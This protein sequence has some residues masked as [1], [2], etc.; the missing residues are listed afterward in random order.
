MGHR[1][2]RTS[3]P[4]WNDPRRLAP[5]ALRAQTWTTAVTYDA[6]TAWVEHARA[7]AAWLIE[8]FHLVD[9]RGDYPWTTTPDDLARHLDALIA[10]GAWVDTQ[11]SVLEHLRVGGGQHAR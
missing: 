7:R 5:F 1:S 9:R 4:G 10:A 11:S 8:V 2:A 3:E 6:A